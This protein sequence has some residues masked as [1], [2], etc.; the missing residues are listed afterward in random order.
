MTK[1]ERKSQRYGERKDLRKEGN[2]LKLST[3]VGGA[4][5][6]TY[7]LHLYVH[8]HMLACIAQ[9]LKLHIHACV[10]YASNRTW[11]MIEILACIGD[12]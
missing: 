11:M 4:S 6:W 3:Q 1:G 9:V 7:L 10:V 8:I 12:S 5:S 2:Q